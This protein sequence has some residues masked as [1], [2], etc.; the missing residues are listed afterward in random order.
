MSKHRSNPQ[1]GFVPAASVVSEPQPNP[2]R[3]ERAALPR[4]RVLER[5]FVVDRLMDAGEIAEHYDGPPQ[6]FLQRID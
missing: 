1:P 4:Y 3:A 6:P 5:A 2:V